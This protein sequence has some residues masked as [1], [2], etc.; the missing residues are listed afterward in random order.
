MKTLLIPLLFCLSLL[1]CSQ[2]TP[3]NYSKGVYLLLD[4]SGT[5]TQELQKARQLINIILA[6]LEPGDTFAVA[7][8]DSGSFSEKDIVAKIVVDGRPS[9]ATKQ[10][11]EF[12]KNIETFVNTITSSAYTDISGGLLQAVEYLNEAN[13]GKKTIM[14][15]SDLKEE[16]PKGFVR[17][18]DIQMDGFNVIALNVTKLRAD[19]Q[20]PQEY[21]DRLATWNDKIAGGGGHWAVVN[22]LDK[23]E[24]ISL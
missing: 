6:G 20:N 16:L 4:T 7:R 18:F 12:A 19:N 9:M 23:P 11:R 8:I 1:G 22:D 13:V 14:I 21:L 15:Y 5:Y 24:A 2:E 3:Q 17:N 10:K